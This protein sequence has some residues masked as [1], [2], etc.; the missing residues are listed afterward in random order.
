MYKV[1]KKMCKSIYNL[2]WKGRLETI[3]LPSRWADRL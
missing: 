1:Q 2:T 3:S